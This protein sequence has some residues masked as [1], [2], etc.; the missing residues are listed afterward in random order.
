MSFRG[1][2]FLR[3]GE[4]IIPVVHLSGTIGIGF[5][6]RNSISLTKMAHAL[7]RAFSYRNAP[8]VAL[9]INSPGGSPVQSHLIYRRIR[10]LSAETGKPVLAAVEDVA[11][12]GG[13]ML[14]CAGD[15]I[16]ADPASIVGSI[17]VASQSFGFV[18]LLDRLGI[19][20]RVHTAGDRK[21]ILDPFRPEKDLDIAHLEEIQHDI[22]QHFIRLVRER[23]GAR[24]AHDPDLFSGLFWSG[25]KARSLGLVD[26]IGDLRSALRARYGDGVRT[27]ILRPMRPSLLRRLFSLPSEVAVDAAIS[28]LESRALWDRFR[29]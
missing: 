29:F 20:R 22:H 25:E 12:S 26:E 11:A 2:P 17:G 6:M 27:K 9:L 18:R 19:E 10:S 28:S 5:P 7:D 3:K 4:P 8:V 14:A 16:I 23:R 13:Y 15:E 24:L 1:L 21:A